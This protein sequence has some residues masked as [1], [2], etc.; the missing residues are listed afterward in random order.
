MKPL[1]ILAQ[2]RIGAGGAQTTV[3]LMTGG[4]AAAGGL[5]G[6]TWEQACKTRP[7]LTLDLFNAN[8]DGTTEVGKGD[9]AVNLSQIKQVDT[10]NLF[11]PGAPITIYDATSLDLATAPIEFKGF[12]RSASRDL[13]TDAVTLNFEVSTEALDRPLLY[14]LFDGTGGIGGTADFKGKEQPAGFGSVF[15]VEPVWFDPTNNIGMIDGYANCTAITQLY[16]GASNFGPR[17]ADYASYAALLAAIVG[18][19]VPPGR[20][21]TCVA[22]GLIG[23]GAPPAGAITADATFGTNRPGAF[24]QRLMTVHAGIS[25]ADIDTAS[26][27]ALDVAVNRATHYW[28]GSQR[29]VRDLIQAIAAS[30]NASPIVTFQGLYSVTRVFGGTNILTVNRQAPAPPPR[31]TKWRSLDADPPTWRMSMRAGRP[32]VVLDV[33]QINYAD[34]LVDM[35]AY[36]PAD[37]YRLGNLVWNAAGAQFLYINATPASGQP[38]PV[39]PATTTAYWSLTKPQPGAADLYYADGTAI[40]ALKPAQAGADVTGSNQALTIVGQGPWATLAD[41]IDSIRAP[42][43]AMVDDGVLSRVEK[44]VLMRTLAQLDTRYNQVL[45][46]ATALALSTTAMTSARTLLYAYL[47]AQTPTYDDLTQDT[48]IYTPKFG[49]RIFSLATWTANNGVIFAGTG[50]WWTLQDASATQTGSLSRSMALAAS[51][52]VSFAVAVL[53]DAVGRATGFATIRVTGT[54][55]TTTTFDLDFDTATGEISADAGILNA[56]ALDAGDSWIV[57]GQVTTGATNTG[58]K[59]EIFPAMGASTTWVAGVAAQRTISIREPRFAA[60]NIWR[61]GDPYYRGRLV[62]FTNQIEALARSISEHDFG[63]DIGTTL[64]DSVTGTT[65]TRAQLLTALG[66]A[67]SIIGQGAFATLSTLLASNSSLGDTSNTFPDPDLQDPAMW[68]MIGATTLAMATTSG[69]RFSKGRVQFTYPTA[70]SSAVDAAK[71]VPFPIESGKLYYFG[72]SPRLLAT[73]T[74]R[75]V[76]VK[77]AWY[78][79]LAGTVEVGTRA[80]I[81]TTSGAVSNFVATIAP[82]PA[83]AVVARYIIIFTTAAGDTTASAYFYDPIVRRMDDLQVA[84]SGA[85]IGDGR[86]I[87]PIINAGL[88]Y[89]YSVGPTYSAAAGTPATAT[90]SLAAGS[91]TIGT[92]VISYNAMSVNVTGTAGSTVVYNLYIDDKFFSGGTQTL[93]ATTSTTVPYQADGRIFL[94]QISVTYPTSGT[95]TGSGGAGGGGG[96][97]C[98]ATYSW[99]DTEEGEMLAEDAW[100]GLPV[101]C[102]NEAGDG[103]EYHP[104]EKISRGSKAIEGFRVTAENGVDLDISIDTPCTVRDLSSVNVTDVDGQELPTKVADALKW[105]GCHIRSV[106]L[107]EVMIISVGG[108]TYAASNRPGDKILTHNLYKA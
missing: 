44:P 75:S 54:G 9:V 88:R 93:V 21:A 46:R 81:A 1:L 96:L 59:L 16:E 66:A 103:F 84:G 85:Q 95:G 24:I 3:R 99:L 69:F 60:G 43:L 91:L 76:T 55:G 47:T 18:G 17:V 36:D 30:C 22:Q 63:A 108:R 53:K 86:N 73:N 4:S 74:G 72:G 102:L 41:S 64:T 94:G 56:S 101:L 83:T 67:A 6:F 38:L 26:M 78:S 34:D 97:E 15:N 105:Q 107:I 77:V 8:L 12:V 32:G 106:G 57:C 19:T 100:V 40:E 89:R 58:V 28:T 104:I 33:S 10:S 82:V 48:T 35:G 45:T 65:P 92:V 13:E 37:T 52:V 29:T 5:G 98:V 79:D 23:L 90:I 49:D 61:L 70:G 7:R 51:S 14:N 39:A 27:A 62:Q 87:I 50:P 11:W 42:I 2:P 71:S 68:T 25:I 31:V 20:W 80:T